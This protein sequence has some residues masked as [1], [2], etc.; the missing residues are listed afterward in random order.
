MQISDLNN[1][2]KTQ[3]SYLTLWESKR[4]Y[5]N[6]FGE[7]KIE[8]R[9]NDVEPEFTS[10]AGHEVDKLINH[11]EKNYSE[12]LDIVFSQYNLIDDSTFEALTNIPDFSL[13]K[14]LKAEEIGKYIRHYRILSVILTS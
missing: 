6:S 12:F 13:P 9:N 1:F 5:K 10:K 14:G 8:Y 7:F 4:P 2:T 11:F 3:Y